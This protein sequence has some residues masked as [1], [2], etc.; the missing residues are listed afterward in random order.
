MIYIKKFEN[1]KK[2]KYL[3]QRENLKNLKFFKNIFKTKKQ[4]DS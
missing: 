3:K 4:T 2:I 1:T